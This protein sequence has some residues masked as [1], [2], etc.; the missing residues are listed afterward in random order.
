MAKIALL[1]GVSEYETELSPLPCAVRDVEAMRDVLQHPDIGGFA[2]SDVTVLKNPKR[3]EME[4]AVYRLF[5]N[6]QRDDLVLFFF[7]GHGIKDKHDSTKFFF[8]TKETCK[9]LE[10][11]ELLD[12]TAVAANF[13]HTHMNR[14]R[15]KRKVI[16]LDCCF[17]GA[18]AKELFRD[19]QSPVDIRA[20]LGGEGRAIL[21][22]STAVQYSFEHKKADLSV[23]TRYLIEGI[24]GAADQD[25][26]GFVSV[27]E[28]HGYA[29]TKVRESQSGM[30]PEI[31]TSGEDSF[32]IRL[33]KVPIHPE[34][35]YRKAIQPEYIDRGEVS[36]FWRWELE[37]RRISL[38]L[39]EAEA[40]EIEAKVLE[41]YRREFEA[42][43]QRYEQAFANAIRRESTL[44]GKTL[45]N[46]KQLQQRLRLDP[47]VVSEIELRVT[48]RLGLQQQKLQQYERALIEA[49][50]QEY[51]LS[52]VAQTQLQQLQ[53]QLELTTN[54]I[55]S[56]Q[57][58]V[59]AEAELYWLRLQ[60]YREALTG[61]TQNRYPLNDLQRHELHRKQQELGLL[62]RD[63]TPILSHI[64]S[65]ID[66]YQQ[67]LQQYEQA[68]VEATQR[69]HL[70]S[71]ST[72][73]RLEQL[74]QSLNLDQKDIAEIAALVTAQIGTH[75][76]KL[77][78]YEQ[79]LEDALAQTY[80]LA[81]D[82]L[83]RLQQSQQQL[84]LTADDIAPSKTRLIARQEQH[85]QK[86]VKYKQMLNEVLER[87]G[88]P[89]SPQTRNRLRNLQR[90][91]NLDDAS[92]IRVEEEVISTWNPAQPLVKRKPLA[93]ANFLDVLPASIPT[94][95]RLIPGTPL[96]QTAIARLSAFFAS[97]HHQLQRIAGAS[98]L[99]AS[100][101][102]GWYF[103]N[104]YEEQTDRATLTQIAT[105]DSGH[106]YDQCI[107]QAQ[108]L[109][110]N[111]RFFKDAQAHLNACRF[112]K[113]KDFAGKS[114]FQD[115]IA[116][117]AQIPDD[118]DRYG[119]LAQDAINTWSESL[120]QQAT[121]LY[122][123]GK[124]DEAIAELKIIPTNN[125]A[126][127]K[128]QETISQWNQ[129][130]TNNA[131]TL[132]KA[133]QALTDK[134]WTLADDTAKKATTAYWKQKAQP[135]IQKAEDELASINAAPPPDPVAI[136]NPSPDNSSSSL[137]SGEP[138]SVRVDSSNKTPAV[139]A[140]PP[141]ANFSTIGGDQ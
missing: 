84:G 2:A 79:A 77:R 5:A 99:T 133:N 8:A 35:E 102:G 76:Q 117:A 61:F 134:K 19:S 100:A 91:L 53:Q 16:I 23:Y 31:Y 58:R 18:F 113:A 36:E 21:T 7:S 38:G 10:D 22:S 68:W 75:Q 90:K 46:L 110:S 50:R 120:I 65:Q 128:A 39:S 139:R 51:P 71:Q 119:H 83:L 112:Y 126:G 25:D 42:A 115:A 70:P 86:L 47:Q 15:S 125:A 95:S 130:W 104:Q 56:T 109:P 49:T 96:V 87:F 140:A 32:S 123:T 132:A 82:Q 55:A 107:T 30:S 20:Q 72:C 43:C 114:K 1:I 73:N 27:G 81:A 118:T 34:A 14:S 135:I 88:I 40:K 137:S 98:V 59:I 85:Y 48:T 131:A 52:V 63:I 121:K 80:P 29:G 6:R 116:L 103:W 44:N 41:P 13:V 12:Y 66:A 45:S 97:H 101:I 4:A 92:A 105:L 37:E 62:D 108:G 69:K 57:S 94:R 129:E 17:S 26:D 127:K 24:K 122:Q 67:Q 111:F 54:D 60:Q 138:P 106:Q 136:T 89:F 74:A 28:L 64:T 3:F 78:Q 33:A 141:P 9:S 124:K 93:I 11:G